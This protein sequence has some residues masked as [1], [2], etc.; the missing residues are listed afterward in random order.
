M[1]V[2]G[3]SGGSIDKYFAGVLS[4]TPG[5]RMSAGEKQAIYRCVMCM[6]VY[7]PTYLHTYNTTQ[8]ITS[9]DSIRLYP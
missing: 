8:Y 4:G 6:P 5:L 2:A 1:C 3:A 7:I 9:L